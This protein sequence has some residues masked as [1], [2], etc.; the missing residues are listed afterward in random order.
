MP[1]HKILLATL[2]LALVLTGCAVTE[3][4]E[5]RENTF[6]AMTEPDLAAGVS[7]VDDSLN[8]SIEINTRGAYQDF[9]FIWGPQEDQFLRGYKFRDTGRVVLQG[10]VTSEI[11]G[12]WLH[13]VSATFQ[14]TLSTRPVERVSFDANRCSSYGCMHREDMVFEFTPEE[15]DQVIADMEAKGETIFAFRIQGQSGVDRD[16]RF[17]INE[18]KA[19]RDAVTSAYFKE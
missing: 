4:L 1:T 10:Y 16:G 19:F 3:T 17:H 12:T 15:L 8:P 5:E 18:L 14:H 11:N 6:L 13:P 7:V 2:A 9:Q